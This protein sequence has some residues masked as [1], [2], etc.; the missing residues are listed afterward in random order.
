MNSVIEAHTFTKTS[1]LTL[2]RANR[3]GSAAGLW[4]SQ[5]VGVSLRN[6]LQFWTQPNLRFLLM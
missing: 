1:T 3:Q 2:D 5:Q 4:G 6:L